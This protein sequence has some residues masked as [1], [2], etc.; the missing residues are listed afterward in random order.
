MLLHNRSR[1]GREVNSERVGFDVK[2]NSFVLFNSMRSTVRDK[3]PFRNIQA[4]LSYKL[5][6]IG[7]ATV[8][9]MS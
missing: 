5:S 4:R 3:K 6:L 1:P 8:R 9:S 7:G 2:E